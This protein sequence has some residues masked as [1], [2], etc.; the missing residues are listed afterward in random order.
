MADT[1]LLAARGLDGGVALAGSVAGV[2]TGAIMTTA[3]SA[4]VIAPEPTGVSKTAGALTAATGVATL[5]DSGYGVYSNVVNLYRATQGSVVYLPDSGSGKLAEWWASG[6]QA[7]QDYAQ[8]GSLGLALLSGRVY[9][10]TTL[11][12][13]DSAYAQYLPATINGML[14]ASAAAPTGAL[15]SVLIPN[16]KPRE[17]TTTKLL[18][19][20]QWAQILNTDSDLIRRFLPSDFFEGGQK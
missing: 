18:N 7:A 12:Y 10:G 19:Q 16:A 1:G 4:L 6:D 2:G 5:A 15:K 11:R 9:V 14:D 3:G 17:S 20:V 8:V 13:G